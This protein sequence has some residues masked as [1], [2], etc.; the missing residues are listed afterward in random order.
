MTAA[1]T[2]RK[3]AGSSGR[4]SV[5]LTRERPVGSE[6][7]GILRRVDRD[8]GRAAPWVDPDDAGRKGLSPEAYA[9]A[10]ATS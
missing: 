9:A 4:R 3:R 8:G 2:Q 1:P 10:Q 7:E 6:L 5:G